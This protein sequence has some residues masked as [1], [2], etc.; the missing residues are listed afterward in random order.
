MCNSDEQKGSELEWDNMRAHE[1]K[2]KVLIMWCWGW[3]TKYEVKRW[4]LKSQWDSDMR[5]E[6]LLDFLECTG[7]YIYNVKFLNEK[8]TTD[9]F[10]CLSKGPETH[11]K[12]QHQK[13]PYLAHNACSA[14]VWPWQYLWIARLMSDQSDAASLF[15][16][17]NM[18]VSLAIVLLN[19]KTSA[20]L[21]STKFGFAMSA[22]H[23]PKAKIIGNC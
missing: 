13:L 9:K 20:V 18:P 12:I 17:T 6:V 2:C 1:Y 21:H 8:L 4:D 15:W 7:E 22:R 23:Q 11:M 19:C 16:Y 10:Y 14:I 3:E 5:V